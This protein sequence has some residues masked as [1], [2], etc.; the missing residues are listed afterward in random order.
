PRQHA[1]R[2]HRPAAPEDP[3]AA[4]CARAGDHARRRLHVAMI[5]RLWPRSIRSRLLATTVLSVGASLIV[6]VLAFNL[7]FARRLDANPTDQARARAQAERDVLSVS[8]GTVQREQETQPHPGDTIWVYANG[9]TI[10]APQRQSSLDGPAARLGA[11]GT[12]TVDVGD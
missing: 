5:H 11:G 8:G 7:L 9:E 4:G 1:R 10:E 2:V 3:R 12:G 6:L